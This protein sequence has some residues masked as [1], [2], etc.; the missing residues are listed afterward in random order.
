MKISWLIGLG[1][2][3]WFLKSLSE[4]QRMV[5]LNR[6][7]ESRAAMDRAFE[8]SASEWNATHSDESWRMPEGEGW[9]DV[10]S[11]SGWVPEEP[12]IMY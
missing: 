11:W 10:L 12:G 2:S 5:Q 3:L 8:L 4:K 6:Q 7:L 1:I 9:P